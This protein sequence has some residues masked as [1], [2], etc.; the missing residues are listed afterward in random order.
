MLNNRENNYVII[1]KQIIK[2]GDYML[3]KI[4]LTT[5]LTSTFLLAESGVGLNINDK[6]LELEATIDSRDL[7]ALQTSSTI[8]QADFNFLNIDEDAKLVGFGIA[9]ANRLEAVEGVELS[10]GGKFIWAEVGDNDFTAFPLVAR[11]HYTFPPLMFNI[12]PVSL[13]GKALYAPKVLSFAN[14]ET[15]QEFR[16]NAEIE[17]IKNVKLYTGYRNIHA[18][19]DAVSQD[20][21]DTGFYGGLRISY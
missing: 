14:S 17:M 11:V 3:I 6:D 19:Y 13:E 18:E 7:Q 5:L 20:L 8:Y 9:A 21:F 1:L 10:F 15:Y 4:A 12:P 2:I 16:L